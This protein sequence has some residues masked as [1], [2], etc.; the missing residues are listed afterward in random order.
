MPGQ[1]PFQP[2]KVFR[3]EQIAE[4]QRYMEEGTAGADLSY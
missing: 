1:L 3:L 4:A 2:G